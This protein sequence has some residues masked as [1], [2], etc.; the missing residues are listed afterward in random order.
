MMVCTGS[1]R[2]TCQPTLEDLPSPFDFPEI[3]TVP[4]RGFGLPDQWQDF[5]SEDDHLVELGPTRDDELCYANPLVFK[6]EFR[7]ILW[8]SEQR[9]RRRTVIRNLAR[10]V[11]SAQPT[12]I[13]GGGQGSLQSL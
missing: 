9:H 7:Q 2:A 5:A 1:C 6:K 3:V 11:I 10:P 12:Y 13:V 4:C 8:R